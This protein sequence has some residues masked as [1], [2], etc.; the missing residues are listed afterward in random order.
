MLRNTSEDDR[1]QLGL[2][3]YR[4]MHTAYFNSKTTQR[5]YTEIKQHQNWPTVLTIAVTMLYNYMPQI[6]LVTAHTDPQL[7]HG[8]EKRTVKPV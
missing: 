1:I 3:Y 5:V 6:V 8:E 7:L 2:S 4:S